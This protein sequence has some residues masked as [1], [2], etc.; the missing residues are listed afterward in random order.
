MSDKTKHSKSPWK[1]HTV[2]SAYSW[3]RDGEDNH[4][5]KV[6]LT[7]NDFSEANA[8]RIIACVNAMENIEDPQA[9]VK[10]ARDLVDGIMLNKPMSVLNEYMETIFKGVRI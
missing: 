8:E 4:V 3:L 6:V 10:A 1:L 9:F 2:D 5:A 7:G